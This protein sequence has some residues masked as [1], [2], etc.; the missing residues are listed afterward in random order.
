MLQGCIGAAEKDLTKRVGYLVAI[1]TI[2]QICEKDL[3]LG[4][5]LFLKK[6]L[7]NELGSMVVE[8]DNNAETV[9]EPPSTRAFDLS[10]ACELLSGQ[11]LREV[12][13]FFS[14]V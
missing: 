3:D 2:H 14:E 6:G 4:K 10:D 1:D 5:R 9:S 8:E 13:E 11:Q 7:F 12:V